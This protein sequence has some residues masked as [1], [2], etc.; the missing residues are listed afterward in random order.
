MRWP[1]KYLAR[2]SNTGLL[3]IYK[4]HWGIQSGRGSR[5]LSPGPKTL[6]ETLAWPSKT[7]LPTLVKRSRSALAPNVLS[8]M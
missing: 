1:K 3:A 7:I 6:V 5:G 4:N 2:M 8:K